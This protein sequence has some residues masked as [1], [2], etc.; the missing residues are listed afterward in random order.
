M[1]GR[2]AAVFLMGYSK[3]WHSTKGWH[4]PDDVLGVIFDFLL[5]ST[6]KARGVASQNGS[7][8]HFAIKHADLTITKMPWHD[9][10][11]YLQT[12]PSEDSLRRVKEKAKKSSNTNAISNNAIDLFR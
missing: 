2:W 9:V 1:V 5:P 4:F 7:L 10:L 6:S 3:G 11:L 12:N 8:S